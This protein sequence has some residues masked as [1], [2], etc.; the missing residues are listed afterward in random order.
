MHPVM[1]SNAYGKGGVRVT[2]VTR[3]K[4]RHTVTQLLCNVRLEGD[5]TETYLTG[6]NSKVIATDSI[7][8]TVY[9]LASEHP[10]DSIES[11][12]IYVVNHFV[13]RYAQVRAA[14]IEIIQDLWDRAA[15]ATGPHA[16]AFVNRGGEKRVTTVELRRGGSPTIESGINGLS[17]LR[18]AG[19]E[20][21]NFVTDEFR[22]LPD[23]HD[24]IFAT[25]VTARW[26][27]NNSNAKFDTAY[28]NTRD[29]IVNVFANHHSLSVQQT[30]HVMGEM[31]LRLSPDIEEINL[32]LPNK[33]HI[34]FDLSKLRRANKNEIFVA[35]DDP[36]G[37]I[38]ETVTRA[39][40]R[41]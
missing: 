20:F 19:S 31:A 26:R 39:R 34:P 2:K 33:H 41:L 22:T 1:K 4:D 15:T 6:D 9:A 27:F 10:V 5:F 8:N 17:V 18:T 7:K 12:G 29:A 35:T 24:R 21:A 14:R 16:T 38:E 28:N 32:V 36:H 40:S 3:G 25:V 30:M 23:T 37:L 13:Q 11:F